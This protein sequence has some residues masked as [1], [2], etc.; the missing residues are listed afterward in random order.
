M[1]AQTQSEEQASNGS[2]VAPTPDNISV[3][4]SDGHTEVTVVNGE[5]S[6][7]SANG[8]EASSTNKS[9]N[10][11]VKKGKGTASSISGKSTSSVKSASAEEKSS[12]NTDNLVG[13]L[14][15]LVTTDLGN[16]VEGRDFL[17]LSKSCMV[18]SKAL[19]SFMCI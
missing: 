15:N 5:G 14:N 7:T 1:K 18:T 8:D 16:I 2:T 10:G 9:S 6:S 19:Y 3:A 13:K 4:D 17:L 12:S 11:D